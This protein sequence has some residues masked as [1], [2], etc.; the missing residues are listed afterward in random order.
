[1]KL[2][3]ALLS[4]PRPENYIHETI[5]SLVDTGFFERQDNLPLRFVTGTREDAYLARYR[6]QAAFAFDVLS[7]E[8]AE[9]IGFAS[10]G[11]KPR[12]AFGHYRAMN[13][14]LRCREEWDAA[15]ICEDDVQ[16]ASGWRS[17]L[18]RVVEGVER[19]FGKRWMLSLYHV[20]HRLRKSMR[21]YFDRGDLWFPPPEAEEFW[22]TQ[23]IL[24]SKDALP[25]MPGCLLEG[26]IKNFVKPVDLTLGEF[27]RREGI[28]LLTT[29]P[30]L[31]Q[32]MGS[33]TTGQSDWFHRAEIF[34]D[35]VPDRR[36]A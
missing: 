21:P 13:H 1:M 6:D 32:H 12:C 22:G 30:S 11:T 26:C 34:F 10:L 33:K 15:L 14:L 24:Y 19:V 20:G 8:E 28:T 7:G 25:A 27:A 2:A 29:V 16:F 36:G 35:Q 5:K 9:E 23:A 4:V 18:E 31:V 3:T 17:Y